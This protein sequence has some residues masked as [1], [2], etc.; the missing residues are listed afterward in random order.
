MRF[1]VAFHGDARL[2]R[3]LGRIAQGVH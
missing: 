2:R 3:V 1:N